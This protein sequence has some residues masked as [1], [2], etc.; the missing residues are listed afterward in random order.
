MIVQSVRVQRIFDWGLTKGYWRS[1]NSWIMV[2]IRAFIAIDISKEIQRKLEEV[3]DQLRSNLPDV[4]V[5]WVLAENIHL[6]LKFLGNVSVSN[7]E[8]LVNILQ[9]E[10]LNHKPF[11]MSIGELGAF[12][13]NRR[14]RVLWIRIQAPTE[15]MDVQRGIEAVTARLGYP[16]EQ[17]PFSPHLTL[18]RVS[19]NASSHDSRKI[20]DALELVKV[21]FLG[22]MWVRAIK[23]YRSDLSPSGAVYTCLHSAEFQTESS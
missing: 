1:K 23:L 13:T 22:A 15:L 14:P 11:E 6:T 17:R 19:R 9:V 12:P 18:G 7:L 3:S 21:G 8:V 4:P 16:S 20:S 2:V 5:R 10:A